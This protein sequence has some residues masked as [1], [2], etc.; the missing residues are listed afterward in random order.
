MALPPPRPLMNPDATAADEAAVPIAALLF[1]KERMLCVVPLVAEESEQALEDL[2]S[3][4]ARILAAQ[5][6]TQGQIFIFKVATS[7]VLVEPHNDLTFCVAWRGLVEKAHY[8]RTHGALKKVLRNFELEIS[9]ENPRLIDG[10]DR[11]IA[12]SLGVRDLPEPSLEMPGKGPPAMTGKATV[13][14]EETSG[15]EKVS[16]DPEEIAASLSGLL[17][18]E[19]EESAAHPPPKE[20]AIHARIRERCGSAK[21]EGYVVSPLERAL[22]APAEEAAQVLSEFEDGLAFLVELT[23]RLKAIDPDRHLPLATPLWAKIKD[24]TALDFLESGL[25][26][27]ERAEQSMDG[28]KGDSSSADVSA[29]EALSAQIK[30]FEASGYKVAA[31]HRLLQTKDPTILREAI[32]SFRKGIAEL[33]ALGA[34]LDQLDTL[35]FEEQAEQVRRLLDDPNKLHVASREFER[36]RKAIEEE[37][38]REAVYQQL[39]SQLQ[40]W[41]KQGYNVSSLRAVLARDQETILSTFKHYEKQVARLLKLESE[42]ERLDTSG[43]EE[44]TD[45][46]RQL[47]T[48][49]SNLGR[50]GN[51]LA[52]L[53]D[54]V[55]ERDA[56]RV[57]REEL[58]AQADQWRKS[59]Y[60]LEDLGALADSNAKDLE[61]AV[62]AAHR[63]VEGQEVLA[64]ELE[65][66]RILGL[67]AEVDEVLPLRYDPAK[68][69]AFKD[70]LTLL[71]EAVE[72]ERRKEAPPQAVTD[73][74]AV[75]AKAVADRATNL[76]SSLWG[77]GHEELAR[78]VIKGSYAWTT[79]DRVVVRIGRRWYHADPADS[80]AFLD[81]FTAEVVT[82][83]NKLDRIRKEREKASPVL[84]RTR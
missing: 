55:A 9:R 51:L 57:R 73:D 61:A 84:L 77:R 68:A 24:V 22:H 59:G 82:H 60:I 15:E 38:S 50:A 6:L 2:R 53:K 34:Q 75:V 79:D 5:Q 45:E 27:L 20:D 12:M 46:I 78:A 58:L 66:Y 70:R 4:L 62:M 37:E 42:L 76:P 72:T 18:D 23:D 10:M 14:M 40:E 64:A 1:K 35:G 63:W 48:D 8:K 39:D 81:P 32:D 74:L 43:F 41:V 25:L 52:S 49:P 83:E 19:P 7:S 65:G 69:P 17:E 36:L 47:L 3:A 26:A 28:A 54:K 11:F 30:G 31:L 29:I 80:K 71:R 44:A 33:E 16:T 21:R 56:E 67:G 13:T